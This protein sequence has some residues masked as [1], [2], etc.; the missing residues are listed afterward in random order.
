MSKD[1]RRFLPSTPKTSRQ[2]LRL[3]ELR[4]S[5][6]ALTAEASVIQGEL[7]EFVGAADGV[8]GSK[9]TALVSRCNGQVSWKQVAEYLA[10][11]LGIGR[12]QFESIT[13]ACRGNNYVRLT[14]REP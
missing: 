1:E 10:D 12:V 14:L 13:S 3:S 4:E 2:M 8:E 7:V 11:E 5:I 9:F 6:R